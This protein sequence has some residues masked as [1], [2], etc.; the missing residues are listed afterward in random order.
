[1]TA[2]GDAWK[3]LTWADAVAMAAGDAAS[4]LSEDD[5]TALL[6]ERTAFPMDGAERTYTAV[7]ALFAREG[8][9]PHDAA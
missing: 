5:M 1:M 2:M 3:W 9:R 6:W 8:V 7:A 4:E